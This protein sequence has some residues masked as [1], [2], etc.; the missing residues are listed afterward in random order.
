MQKFPMTGPGLQRL[1]DE[2]R[3][4]KSEERP[5]II[6]AIAEAR[7]HGDLSENAEYHAARE[8]QSFTEGR[9]QELEEIVSSAEVIDPAS[10]SGDQVKFGARVK[11]VDEETDREASYQI[12]GV[13][14]A[15]I[16]QGLLSIS[17]PLAKSLIG[18]S[19]GDTVSVPAPGGDR[20]YEILEVTYG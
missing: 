10:L 13:Y 3:K 1:E 14:E 8:R 6:R 5:A 20:T 12:V 19:I 18:K 11:L 7:S 4:L 2:L 17:S 9:I 15:D 16:K